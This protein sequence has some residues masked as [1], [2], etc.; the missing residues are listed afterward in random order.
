MRRGRRHL[1]KTEEAL[2][3]FL[4]CSRVMLLTLRPREASKEGNDA[5][6][7]SGLAGGA[8]GSLFLKKQAA[9]EEKEWNCSRAPEQKKFSSSSLKKTARGECS[10]CL[11]GAASRHFRAAH[12]ALG[13]CTARS[14]KKAGTFAT[15]PR[16]RP[17]ERERRRLTMQL[18]PQLLL[19]PFLPPLPLRGSPARSRLQSTPW[20]RTPTRRSGS[21][22]RTPGRWR[23]RL[24]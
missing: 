18:L 2:S 19:L 4:E 24:L 22:S 6:G 21:S 20:P 14:H 5:R 3:R 15:C 1:E 11:S 9:E 17:T 12:D 7:K 16:R 8:S 10:R 13:A 23:P